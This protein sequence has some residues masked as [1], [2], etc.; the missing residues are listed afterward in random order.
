MSLVLSVP[1]L[2]PIIAPARN[3]INNL[4]D[5]IPPG[6]AH[7]PFVVLIQEAAYCN[8]I[9]AVIADVTRRY[10]E[11]AAQFICFTFDQGS[12]LPLG[13]SVQTNDRC[14]EAPFCSGIIGLETVPVVLY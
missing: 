5:I 14:S 8:E 1:L 12:H 7:D 6:W 13:T 2:S 11:S 4:K 3:I 10:P 9:S